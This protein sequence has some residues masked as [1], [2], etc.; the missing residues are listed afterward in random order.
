MAT[1]GTL[2]I[3]NSV[4]A[5][6]SINQIIDTTD[7]VVQ[8]IDTVASNSISV[9]VTFFISQSKKFL[10]FLI[11]KN[12]VSA[13]IAII[14]GTQ[15]GK[16]TGSF[17]LHLLSPFINL[18]FAGDTNNFDDYQIEFRGVYFKIG[19]FITNLIS[20]LINMIMVYYVFQIAQFS[21][22]NFDGMLNQSVAA[23]TMAA[24]HVTP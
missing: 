9:I 24:S 14:V 17:V 10:K 20:F 23:N 3:I 16:I 13:G 11:D 6:N 19:S 12:V 2:N 5:V 7:V 15:V 21:T 1:S 8:K 18:I 4:N 22:G